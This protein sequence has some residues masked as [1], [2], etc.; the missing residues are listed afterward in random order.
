MSMKTKLPETS[1]RLPLPF[2]DFPQSRE[3]F[4]TA[5]FSMC[6]LS[7]RVLCCCS[8]LIHPLFFSQRPT[9]WPLLPFNNNKRKVLEPWSQCAAFYVRAADAAPDNAQSPERAEPLAS[10]DW[11]HGRAEHINHTQANRKLV[12]RRATRGHQ[13]GSGRLF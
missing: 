9:L 8:L 4:A 5:F 3:E 13:G 2:L 1:P 7:T 12:Q 10:S 6:F 11:G